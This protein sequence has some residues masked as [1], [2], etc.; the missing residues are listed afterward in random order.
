VR[1]RLL[2]AA[3]EQDPDFPDGRHVQLTRF[4][5]IGSV[6][7]PDGPVFVVQRLAVLTGMPAPRGIPRL[8]FY[9]RRY[10][11]L[12]SYYWPRGAPLWCEGSCLYLRGTAGEG[13]FPA[14]PETRSLFA[15]D[16]MP[17]GNVVDF[18]AGFDGAVLKMERRYGSSGGVGEAEGAP[19]HAPRDA[20]GERRR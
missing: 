8:D 12:A 13:P 20:S 1:A 2:A 10:D 16:E 11:L 9:D 15:A 7:T 17:C 3:R 5:Y 18:S 6:D 19:A 4:A 14:T